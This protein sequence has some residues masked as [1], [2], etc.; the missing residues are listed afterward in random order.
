MVKTPA[1]FGGKFQTLNDSNPLLE[2]NG[3]D[4]HFA[5][6]PLSRFLNL[7]VLVLWEAREACGL[8]NSPADA[9]LP[10]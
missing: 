6:R 7:R 3:G 8:A 4:F 5:Q 1:L 9:A 10:P 2:K